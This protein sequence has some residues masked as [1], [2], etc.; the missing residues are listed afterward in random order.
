MTQHK[1]ILDCLE[2]EQEYLLFALAPEQNIDRMN[3][4]FNVWLMGVEQVFDRLVEMPSQEYLECY[5]ETET[6]WYTVYLQKEAAENLVQYGQSFDVRNFQDMKTLRDILEDAV[7]R[8][9]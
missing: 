1:H 9:L 2:I 3:D 5:A 4:L 6:E 8:R 7:C